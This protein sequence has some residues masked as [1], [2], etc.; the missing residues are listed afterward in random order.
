MLENI[1]T[2]WNG[3]LDRINDVKHCI[4]L[5]RFDPRQIRPT[6]FRAVSKAR[7]SEKEEF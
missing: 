7:E 1:E 4:E 2:R 5:E 6:P 3:D